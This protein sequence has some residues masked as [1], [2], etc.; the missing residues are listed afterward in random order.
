MENFLSRIMAIQDKINLDKKFGSGGKDIIDDVLVVRLGCSKQIN[1]TT[2]T[3]MNSAAYSLPTSYTVLTGKKVILLRVEVTPSAIV[4]KD[5][6]QLVI[7]ADSTVVKRIPLPQSDAGALKPS[8]EYPICRE[9][10][11]GEVVTVKGKN[12]SGAGDQTLIAELWL[13]SIA[14]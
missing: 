3:L 12:L 4:A 2:E 9:F 7:L 1:S 5:D 14:A 10:A 11:A 8:R 6:A 13:I